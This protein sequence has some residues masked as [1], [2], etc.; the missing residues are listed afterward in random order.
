MIRKLLVPS[1][2]AISTFAASADDWRNRSIYQLVTDRFATPDGS[3]P[4]CDTSNRKYCGG[5]WKGVVNKLDYIQNMG[6]DAIWISPI[7][8]NVESTTAYGEA[9]HGYWTEDINSLNSHFGSGDDLKALS[10]ALHD[11]QMYLMVDVV[12]N[13]MAATSDPP[14]YSSFEPF[15]AQADF[16]SECFI[17]DYNN[18]TDV[19][20]CWLGDKNL[21]LAD[22]NTEDDNIVNTMNT[23]I[24][25]LVNNYTV[26]GV[27]IDTVKHIRKDFWP[28][29][30]KSAGV[31]TIGEVLD[32]ATT[33][34]S[35]YTQVIDSVL[36][37]PTWFALTSAFQTPQG[38]LSALAAIVQ[39]AQSSY[40]NGEFMT[41]SFLENHDQPRFQSLTQD[42]ALVK[43]AMTWPFVQDGVP[44]LYYGQEQ[45][46]AGGADPANRE[47]LWLSGYVEDKPLVTH[48]KT[49]NAARKAAISANSNFLTSPVKF[50]SAEGT[51]VAVSKAPMLALLTNG[52]NSSTPSWSIPAAGYQAN[53]ELVDILTC[54]KINADGNGGVSV[55]GTSGQPQ[56]IMPTSALSKSGTL[57]ANVATGG[58]ASGAPALSPVPTGAAL[59]LAFIIANLFG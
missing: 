13:H 27:R 53:E 47:A 31:F 25:T 56:V 2:L 39:Q 12:V 18:Q 37:Y 55:Q 49:L 17:T 32:N 26:D 44:I 29:F 59:A 4:A 1:L 28:N 40:K 57:C 41:G 45:A 9:F 23:W 51:T 35:A 38:N 15:S 33:Y 50:L 21:P 5:T 20:Q 14:N 6:F 8:A 11:R 52:G 43:N 42:Q 48:V 19:E 46:Y 58:Q 54:T 22:L 30:A 7:V 10:S 3:S 16:H 34:V 24:T 36:D